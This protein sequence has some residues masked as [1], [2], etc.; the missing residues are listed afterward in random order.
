MAIP[1]FI[2]KEGETV[3]YNGEGQFIF[4]IPESHFTKTAAIS[5]E[6][7][8]I[9]G[10][11]NYSICKGN[12]KDYTENI[13]MFNYPSRFVTKPGIIEKAKNIKLIDSSDPIDYRLLIYENN[14][15]DEIISSV[16][17]PEDIENVEDFFRLFVKTGDI[18]K[19][20]P[21][22][23]LYKYFL[24]SINYNGASYKISAQLFGL[25]VSE[26]C[27]DPKDLSKPFRLSGSNN[28]HDYKSIAINKI[29][30][31]NGPYSSITSENWDLSLIGAINNPEAKESPLEKV[32]MGS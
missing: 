10:I 28:M 5:G 4:F 7:I 17:V 21:Y 24:D 2:R 23:Q 22:D 32:I 18:P 13:K 6:Y 12:T 27:R 30:K 20:I 15:Y 25:I 9:L 16:M 19:T 31:Y 1:N 26:M 8:S 3:Y 29:P 11:L 14:K